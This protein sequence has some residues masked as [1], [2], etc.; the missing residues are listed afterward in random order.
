MA[1]WSIPRQPDWGQARTHETIKWIFRRRTFVRCVSL[2]ICF[3]YH[4]SSG[5]RGGAATGEAG[6][7]FGGGALRSKEK[8]VCESAAAKDSKYTTVRCR[9]QAASHTTLLPS[10]LAAVV[11][12]HT[13][14]LSTPSASAPCTTYFLRKRLNHAI[15]SVSFFFFVCA[16]CAIVSSRAAGAC[17]PGG[18]GLLDEK[19][20]DVD[21]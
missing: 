11:C 9:R 14:L 15:T 1:V 6:H 12:L 18:P 4:C 2:P 8:R 19:G 20:A 13:L 5:G 7:V 17:L 3:T 10:H 16:S 21:A